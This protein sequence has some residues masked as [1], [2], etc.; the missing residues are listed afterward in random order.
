MV[1]AE[2]QSVHDSNFAGRTACASRS[3]A[4]AVG[5]KKARDARL[6]WC[7]CAQSVGRPCPTR[8]GA[9]RLACAAAQGSTPFHCGAKGVFKKVMTGRSESAQVLGRSLQPE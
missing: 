5:R 9:Q 1:E 7:S 6:C 8:K 4:E 3:D 2:S